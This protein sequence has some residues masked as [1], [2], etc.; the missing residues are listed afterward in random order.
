MIITVEAHK[1]LTKEAIRVAIGKI[2]QNKGLKMKKLT[3]SILSL[4]VIA[5]TGCE[6]DAVVASK[7]LS[8]KADRFEIDRR[9]VFFNGITDTYILEVRGKCAIN[10]DSAKKLTVTC[11]TGRDKF[12][13]HFL[14]LS[15][16]VTYFAEQMEGKNVSRYQL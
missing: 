8:K 2:K 7:N 1:E 11:M 16:N 12:K 10:T 4:I 13:K 14:G 3:T 9:V 6:T 5:L 15:D